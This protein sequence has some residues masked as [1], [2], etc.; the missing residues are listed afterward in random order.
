VTNSP[1]RIEQ[2]RHADL[3]HLRQF[4]DGLEPDLDAVSV[5]DETAAGICLL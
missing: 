5:R 2:I 1:A 4:A 3:P